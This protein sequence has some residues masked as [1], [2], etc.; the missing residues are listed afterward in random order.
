V[1]IYPFQCPGGHREDVVR[2]IDARDRPKKCSVCR[3]PMKRQFAAFGI[4][5]EH[6]AHTFYEHEREAWALATGQQHQSAGEL[7][8]WCA[9]NGKTIVDPGFKPKK[10]E[11]FSEKEALGALDKIYENNH[12]L[13]EVSTGGG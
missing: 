8:D 4:A 6:N 1:P 10:P 9:K 11:D 13:G 12:S 2:K 5:G 3:E 7:K